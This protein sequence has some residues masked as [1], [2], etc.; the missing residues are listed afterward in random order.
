M[1]TFDVV[2]KVDWQE[3]DNAL[4]QANKELGQR[5]DFKGSDTK[6]EVKDEAFLVDSDD[7]YKVKAAV[8]VLE[9]KLAK[10]LVPLGALDRG[11]VEAAGAGRARQRIGVKAGVEA[12][13]AKAIVKDVKARK[14]K[15]QVAIQGETLRVTGKKR[16]DLQEVMAFLREGDW[17]QPLQYENFRD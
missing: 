1:P 6:I 8:E 9:G 15:V 2:S 4:N 7:E 16:D 10:R 12:T 13:V 14:F 5:Y 11:L 3:V 17:G